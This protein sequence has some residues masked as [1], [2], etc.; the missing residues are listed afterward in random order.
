MSIR[1]AFGE[2]LRRRFFDGEGVCS[3]RIARNF[4]FLANYRDARQIPAEY[5]FHFVYDRSIAANILWVAR[6]EGMPVMKSIPKEYLLLFNA[7]SD[8]E[9]VLNQ[10]R[11]TLIAAQRQA[12]ELYLSV[13]DEVPESA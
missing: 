9:D 6:K 3:R 13:P 4:P 12:E 10:L 5:L 8:A 1:S 11:E 2:I 7:I